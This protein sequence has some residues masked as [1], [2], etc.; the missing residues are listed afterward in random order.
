MHAV[1]LQHPKNLKMQIAW[2][3]KYFCK[4]TIIIQRII[5]TL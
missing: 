5:N 3:Y 2:I 4:T 1:T